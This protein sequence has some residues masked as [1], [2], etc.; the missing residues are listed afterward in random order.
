MSSG[1]SQ[2]PKAASTAA[3]KKREDEELRVRCPRC[4]R[5]VE[6]L[7]HRLCRVAN[8]GNARVGDDRV[9]GSGRGDGERRGRKS[10]SLREGVEAVR[11]VG[12]AEAIVERDTHGIAIDLRGLR[13]RRGAGS[14]ECWRTDDA[15]C[16]DEAERTELNGLTGRKERLHP[17]AFVGEQTAY[18]EGGR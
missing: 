10:P 5:Y 6:I 15:V 3:E 14:G 13:D 11:D 16:A 12:R 18:E 1:S 2:K 7:R 8:Q 4:E 9:E 17:P